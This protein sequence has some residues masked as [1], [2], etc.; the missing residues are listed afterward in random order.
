MDLRQLSPRYF[1]SSQIDPADMPAIKAAGITLVLCNRPNDEVPPCHDSAAMA[2][3]AEDA[4]LRF[5]EVPLTM[6]TIV[7]QVIAENPAAGAATGEVVLAYCASG[8][9]S[10]IAWSLA[11]AGTMPIEDILTAGQ[12]AGYDF[13]SMRRILGA[14][15]V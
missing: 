4:D 9:R 5:A 12:Q 7:P 6:Q 11:Q 13:S 14:P 1:V 3:A 8:T 2:R 15:F 10:A